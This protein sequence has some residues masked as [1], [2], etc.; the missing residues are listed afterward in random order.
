MIEEVLK[1]EGGVG[2]GEC[3]CRGGIKSA[4]VSGGRGEG[5]IECGRGEEG[6]RGHKKVES[7]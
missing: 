7:I 1:N 6:T 2:G 3:G 4:V 5:E